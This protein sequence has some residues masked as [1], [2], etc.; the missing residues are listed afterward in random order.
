MST[1]DQLLSKARQEQVKRQHIVDA[2]N[3]KISMIETADFLTKEEKQEA[4]F[5]NLQRRD[6]AERELAQYQEVERLLIERKGDY[7]N[8]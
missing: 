4:L 1:Y 5:G 7:E 8:L 3:E 2:M 6:S